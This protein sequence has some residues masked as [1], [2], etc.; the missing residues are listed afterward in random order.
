MTT[1]AAQEKVL[2][3]KITTSE[4]PIQAPQNR[5]LQALRKGGINVSEGPVKL[6]LYFP[7]VDINTAQ[8]TLFLDFA[9]TLAFRMFG[10]A[11]Y[12]TVILFGFGFTIARE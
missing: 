4:G 2:K 8:K 9:S 11:Q 1:T 12:L 3:I 6:D 7:I 10:E 5:F